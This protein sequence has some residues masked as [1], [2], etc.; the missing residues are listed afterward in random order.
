MF[1]NTASFGQACGASLGA[2]GDGDGAVAHGDVVLGVVE[3]HG[4]VGVGVC[5][6]V[7]R[8]GCYIGW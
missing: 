5:V 6:K 8:I 7:D 2:H 3:S 4:Q 1:F